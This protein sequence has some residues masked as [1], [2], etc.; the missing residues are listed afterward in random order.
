[1]S[2]SLKI[3]LVQAKLTWEDA[4]ENRRHFIE[5]LARC[6]GKDLVVLPEMFSTGFHMK[7]LNLAEK[8]DGR[9]VS[10]LR[11]M[12]ARY[13]CVITGSLIIEEEGKFYNRL[14]WANN[15]NIDGHYD[16]RHLFRM[17]GEHHEYTGGSRKTLFEINNWK[18]LPL[19]CYDLRFP[20]WSRNVDQHDLMLYVANWPEARR[21][22]WNRLLP[23]RAIENQCFVIGVNR[24]GIDGND[25]SYSGDSTI[26][27][28]LGDYVVAP[29]QNTEEVRTATLNKDLLN[30]LREKFPV[31]MDADRFTIDR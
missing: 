18:I 28:P 16:K 20:V 21:Q 4:A 2:D 22:A 3:A 23:A 10:W 31:H 7:P 12:S 25:I 6:E 26:I 8:M 27:D 30:G 1:M 29:L 11:D 17:A 14:I 19:I 15:G 13:N 9:T 5:L 24:V